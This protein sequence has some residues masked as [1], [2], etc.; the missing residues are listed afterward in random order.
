MWNDKSGMLEEANLDIR[1][2]EEK[3]LQGLTKYSILM[4]LQ[5][6]LQFEVNKLDR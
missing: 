2:L 3:E 5:A 6:K 1:G 4:K